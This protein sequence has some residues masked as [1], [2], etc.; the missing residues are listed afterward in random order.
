MKSKATTVAAYLDS[1]PPDRKEAIQT[2]RRVILKNLDRKGPEGKGG[3]AE[4]M[5][6]GMI[7]YYVPLSVWPHGHNGDPK[8]VV[9]Y[10]ALGSQKNY[11]VVHVMCVWGNQPMRAWFEK[12]WKAT[13]KKLDMGGACLRFKKVEDLSLEVIGEVVRRVPV[14]EYLE[15]Y[16]GALKKAGKGVDGKPLKKSEGGAKTKSTPPKRKMAKKKA[17]AKRG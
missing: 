13:G 15:H 2:V 4:G 12:A 17:A 1:L 11:M 3:Y 10:M 7:G 14:Q 8:V 5:L 9:P 16:T 6:Y